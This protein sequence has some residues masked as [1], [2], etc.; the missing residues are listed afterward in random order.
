MINILTR[1]CAPMKITK[2]ILIAVSIVWTIVNLYKAVVSPNVVDLTTF[3]AIMPIISSLYSEIDWIYVRWNKT[4]AYFILKTVSFTPK[5]SIFIEDK[6]S[7]DEL[8]KHVKNVLKTC[9]CNIKTPFVTRTHEDLYIQLIN[10]EGLHIDVTVNISQECMGYRLTIKNEYQ[11][12]YRD[13]KKCWS[14]FLDIRNKLFSEFAKASNT[15]ERYDVTIYTGKVKNY[16]P[17]YRLTI[18]HIGQPKIQKF[19]LEFNDKD[20]VVK[21]TANKIYGSSPKY[22]DIERLIDEYVPLSKVL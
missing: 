18:R 2:I 12:A 14:M 10:A 1:R 17:F 4:K 15:K 21:T 20:L 7:I 16:N 11:I 3:L 19:C 6:I 13:V 22:Q 5:S 8:E 9:N